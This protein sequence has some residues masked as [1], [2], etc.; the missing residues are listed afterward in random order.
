MNQLNIK[1]CSLYTLGLGMKITADEVEGD[2]IKISK[3][4]W[5]QIAERLME[6]SKI[7]EL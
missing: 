6:Q 2:V 3:E 4:L 7:K 1:D 5:L